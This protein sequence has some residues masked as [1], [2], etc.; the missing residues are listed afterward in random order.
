[1]AFNTPHFSEDNMQQK[2]L[3]IEVRSKVGK[4]ISR[5]LRRDSR[6]PAVVYGKGIEPV[7]V[8]VAQKDLQTAIAG[9]GG[10]NNLLTLNGGGS[11]DKTMA[12]IAD[13]QRDAVKGTIKH[14][15]LHQI[16]MSEKI[17][18]HVPVLL[19]GAA[20]GVKV[21]GGL[22]DFAH[23]TLHIE[24]LPASIPDNIEINVTDLKIGQSIHVS[25][26]SMPAG[27][28]A[29]DNPKAPVVSILGKAREEAAEAAA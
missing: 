2:Q 6:I 13:L 8:S 9:E 25:E 5:Q 11:L 16:N 27:V 1:M 10:Y 3:D 23:H 18:L 24:C 15:D 29:L 12:I 26:V 28:K 22:L 21:Q 7:A 19:T 14:V 17:R 20:H 4:G